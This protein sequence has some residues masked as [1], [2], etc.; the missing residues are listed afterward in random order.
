MDN[1]SIW[2]IPQSEQFIFVNMEL[3]V[4]SRG[5]Y[6]V[7]DLGAVAGIDQLIRTERVEAQRTAARLVL[8]FYNY[9]HIETVAGKIFSLDDRKRHEK[10]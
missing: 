10:I 6:H 5:D 1:K 7:K 8:C 2:L 4:D 3:T 9:H